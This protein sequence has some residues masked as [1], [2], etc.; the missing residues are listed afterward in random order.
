MIKIL[1]ILQLHKINKFLRLFN[2]ACKNILQLCKNFCIN[3]L[4]I[5]FRKRIIFKQYLLVKNIN[6]RLS[7]LK[8]IVKR[9]I[10]SKQKYTLIKML[11]E[12]I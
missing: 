8:F 7:Y 6:M 1:I 2:E 9:D 3:E 11:L 5:S 10:R 12:K 4:L